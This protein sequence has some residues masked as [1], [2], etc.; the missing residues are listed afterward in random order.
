M[1]LYDIVSFVILI[2]AAMVFMM[3]EVKQDYIEC[4]TEF[5]ASQGIEYNP[6]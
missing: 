4:K 1:K 6:E 2:T 5:S 3:R